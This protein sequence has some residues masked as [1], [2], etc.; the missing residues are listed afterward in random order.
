LIEEERRKP[1]PNLASL[2]SL[3]E[4]HIKR[5][6][7]L[8]FGIENRSIQNIEFEQV[9]QMRDQLLNLPRSGSAFRD[10]LDVNQAAQQRQT[11]N[12]DR[13]VLN[14]VQNAMQNPNLSSLKNFFFPGSKK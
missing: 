13:Q 2:I 11:Q 12:V 1:Q 9:P 6:R 3:K 7:R 5:V 14:L 8:T 4:A 10:I